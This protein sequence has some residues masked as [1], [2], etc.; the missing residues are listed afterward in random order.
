MGA[1]HEHDWAHVGC[2]VNAA[3]VKTYVLLYI[4]LGYIDSISDTHNNCLFQLKHGEYHNKCR[5]DIGNTCVTY[6]ARWGRLGIMIAI[7]NNNIYC[8]IYI[9]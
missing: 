2:L 8:V 9:A 6:F 5:L 1:Q 3:G 4:L 7:D